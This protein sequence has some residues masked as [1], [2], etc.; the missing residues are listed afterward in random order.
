VVIIVQENHTFD[1]YFG[2]W[3]A[4]ATGSNPTCTDGPSCC[5][6][7]PAKDP[8]GAS[9]LVLDDTENAAY[10]PNHTQACELGEMDDGMMDKYVTGQPCSDPEN[11]AYAGAVV[12][13][14]RDLAADNAI[15]D[16]YF[17]PIAGQSSSNDMYLAVAKEVFIDNAYEP[18]FTGSQCSISP[19]KSFTGATIA[20]LLK[21]AG[22][23]AAWYSEGYDA[24]KAA[25]ATGCPTA[26]AECPLHFPTYPCVFDPGDIPFAYY[27]QFES[28]GSTFVRDYTEL[29]TD[30]AAGQ[31]PNVVY[32]K[33][34]GYHSEHPGYG[35]TISAGV[36]FVTSVVSAL[37]ESCYA[38]DT[39]ILATWDEGGGFFDHV[40]PPGTSAVDNQ[41][42][43]T[44]I[45]LLA[46]GPF[47]KKGTVSHVQMEHSSIVKFL[48]W[49]FLGG[50]TGQLQARDAVVNNIGSLLDSS[51]IAVPV[52][53]D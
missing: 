53:T 13:P 30:M 36:T 2:T 21:A 6:A 5:E 42:Y 39:L 16:R 23:T 27:T 15:A 51:K 41:P 32:V 26:P 47:A 11:F 1:S 37:Q 49:N 22:K 28:S 12:Q 43:G 50:K 4:A 24:M 14:Y 7:A 3:C 44:R 9:P 35:D 40:A 8:T 34:I 52:P 46:I 48:E 10:D 17:Q 31:M 18:D 25:G 20:D 38:N 29:A 45:P 33:G 19:P